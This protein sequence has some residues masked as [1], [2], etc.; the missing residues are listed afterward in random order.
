M[1]KPK[2]S[3][4]QNVSVKNFNFLSQ[5]P[6]PYPPAYTHGINLVISAPSNYLSIFVISFL[7]RTRDVASSAA[8]AM[9][10]PPIR[11][12]DSPPVTQARRRLPPDRTRDATSPRSFL[13]PSRRAPPPATLPPPTW[14]P[15]TPTHHRRS[16]QG[17]CGT[18][19]AG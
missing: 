18:S 7:C 4:N 12:A 8:H 14:H 6:L 3:T 13:C 10:P 11:D 9:S 1:T 17:E 2:N 19:I 15:A 5:R 16:R